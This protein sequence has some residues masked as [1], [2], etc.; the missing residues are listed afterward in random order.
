MERKQQRQRVSTLTKLTMRVRRRKQT[1]P[2]HLVVG[3]QLLQ[4]IKVVQDQLLLLHLTIVEEGEAVRDKCGTTRIV[5]LLRVILVTGE[6]QVRLQGQ[7][8]NLLETP[9]SS[10]FKILWHTIRF[11]FLLLSSLSFLTTD[12]MYRKPTDCLISITQ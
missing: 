9:V 5:M 12:I 10:S 3:P 11:F 6:N 4:L 8:R 2:I 7:Q 1:S